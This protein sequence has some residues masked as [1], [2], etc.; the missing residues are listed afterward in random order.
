[1]KNILSLFL[2]FAFTLSSYGQLNS[3]Y[4]RGYKDGYCK[5]KKEDKGQYT[6]CATSPRAPRPK[7][8]KA[9][10]NAGVLAGYKYYFKKDN[11]KNGLIKG[12]GFKR[13]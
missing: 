10:Y 3:N 2:L 12:A 4:E 6:T 13:Y 1:M 9:T 8:R 7:V 5:A 11:A